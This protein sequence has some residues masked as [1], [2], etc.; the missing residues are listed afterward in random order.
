M[1]DYQ[2]E[3]DDAHAAREEVLSAAK[4]SEKKA[5]SLEAELMQM[6]EVRRVSPKSPEASQHS[7][8]TQG[9]FSSR[10]WRQPRGRGSRPRPS[11]TNWPTS[12]PATPL[13]SG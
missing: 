12:W 8:E 5:K 3:L 11:G 6:Q 9:C 7:L 13:G 10:T 1:K 4:E 2:R